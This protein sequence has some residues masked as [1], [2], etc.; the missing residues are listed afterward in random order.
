[1]SALSICIYCKKSFATQR[2]FDLHEEREQ[3]TLKFSL[4]FLQG[5]Q[6]DLTPAEPNL[7]VDTE[8]ADPIDAG[9]I[10]SPMAIDLSMVERQGAMISNV[11]TDAIFQ[12][13]VEV[14]WVPKEALTQFQKAVL[15]FMRLLEEH[16]TPRQHQR[17][18]INYFDA[19]FAPQF[20]TD[21]PFANQFLQSPDTYRRLITKD[22]TLTVKHHVFLNGCYLFPTN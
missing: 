10:G 3:C 16:G 18:Y 11:I 9:S 8:V 12:D 2:D 6:I 7:P 20:K 13:S 14:N 5:N 22:V 19:N 21:G 17:D 15:E 1:M 4:N